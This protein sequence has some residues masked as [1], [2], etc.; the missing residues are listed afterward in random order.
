[1]AR[2]FTTKPIMSVRLGV[3]FLLTRKLKARGL[4]SI[5]DGID[6][7]CLYL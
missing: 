3:C 6:D 1:M 2:L 4:G 7:Y 5:A